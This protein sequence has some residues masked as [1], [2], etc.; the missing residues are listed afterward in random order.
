[1]AVDGSAFGQECSGESTWKRILRTK[2][3]RVS[4]VGTTRSSKVGLDGSFTGISPEILRQ[5]MAP[6]GVTKLL[7]VQ[8]DFPSLFPALTANRIES[9][10]TPCRCA[11]RAA[12]RSRLP[13][14]NSMRASASSCQRK[15]EELHS[16]A[17][18]HE[19]GDAARLCGR[20]IQGVLRTFARVP[21][22]RLTLRIGFSHQGGR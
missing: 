7:P 3:I 22:E 13:I 5:I 15:S 21:K 12:R 1:M 19:R 9:S 18:W 16:F 6:H 20:R 10:P 8:M 11:K 2:T 17:T 14:L 4:T